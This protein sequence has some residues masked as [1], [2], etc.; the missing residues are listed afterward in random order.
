[1][2]STSPEIPEEDL[3]RLRDSLQRALQ[4]QTNQIREALARIHTQN[5]V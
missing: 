4:P 2:S 5:A 3:A 1:M